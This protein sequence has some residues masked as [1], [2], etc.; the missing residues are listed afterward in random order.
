M[1]SFSPSSGGS[2]L[3]LGALGDAG[4]KLA[5][6]NQ[7]NDDRQAQAAQH[8]AKLLENSVSDLCTKASRQIFKSILVVPDMTVIYKILFCRKNYSGPV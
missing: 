4:S 3:K 5:S 7:N 2:G 6:R 8:A 1:S